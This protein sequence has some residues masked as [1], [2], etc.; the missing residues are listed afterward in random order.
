L[1]CYHNDISNIEID[2]KTLNGMKSMLKSISD[3]DSAIV[4]SLTR[5]SNDARGSVT[6]SN[7][8]LLAEKISKLN[9]KTSD[10]Q[11]VMSQRITCEINSLNRILNTLRKADESYHDSLISRGL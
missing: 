11:S 2:I 1:P 6:P 7:I 3:K 10:N 5:L 4:S 8:N 9:K